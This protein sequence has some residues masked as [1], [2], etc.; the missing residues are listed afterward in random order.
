MTD[1]GRVLIAAAERSPR[2]LAV[3]DGEKRFDYAAWL[4]TV[5]RLAAGPGPPR[6]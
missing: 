5:A 1:L 6:A 3:V 2:A 4:D